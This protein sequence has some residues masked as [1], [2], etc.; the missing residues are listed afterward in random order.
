MHFLKYSDQTLYDSSKIQFYYISNTI[1]SFESQGI[2]YGTNLFSKENQFAFL[3]VLKK[4]E[5]STSEMLALKF[6]F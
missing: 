1:F 3:P 2:L 5:K 4:R 6:K